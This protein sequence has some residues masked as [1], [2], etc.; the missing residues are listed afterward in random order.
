MGQRVYFCPC[1]RVEMERRGGGLVVVVIFVGLLSCWNKKCRR[2]LLWATTRAQMLTGQL[3]DG[4]TFDM[5]KKMYIKKSNTFCYEFAL[6]NGLD[7]EVK[8]P[9]C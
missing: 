7:S 9:L 5:T 1:G 8:V 6:W 2:E 3:K 4:R